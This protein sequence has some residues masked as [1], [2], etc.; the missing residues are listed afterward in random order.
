MKQI[1]ILCYACLLIIAFGAGLQA[2]NDS[3]YR[4]QIEAMRIAFFTKE[5]K[6]SPAEAKVFWP[7]YQKFK[8]D[9]MNLRRMHPLNRKNK[10]E[11]VHALSE[12]QATALL[13][14]TI[15]FEK[16]MNELNE[17][18]IP[19]FRKVLSDKKIVLMYL[20][21]RNFRKELLIRAK[22]HHKGMMKQE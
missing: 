21:E 16:Q 14:Q 9:E 3:N 19:E 20:A 12:A 10:V 6:L 1:K 5:M 22:D 17:Q 7:V 18:Y 8:D 11:D 15:Q 13:A 2:Q 4:E